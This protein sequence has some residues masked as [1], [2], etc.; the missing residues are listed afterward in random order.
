M[1]TL[2]PVRRISSKCF[3]QKPLSDELFLECFFE[4][5][6]PDRVFIYLHDSNSIFRAAGIV[7]EG[8]L[9][10]HGITEAATRNA[11]RERLEYPLAPE[12]DSAP[13]STHDRHGDTCADQFPHT[14]EDFVDKP[15]DRYL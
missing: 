11:W 15:Q 6:E 2:K 5:S 4:S 13:I 3:A 10:R 1:R 9:G 8:V 7:S 14:S 12:C